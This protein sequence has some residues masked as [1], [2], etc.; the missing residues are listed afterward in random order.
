[1][2]K[3]QSCLKSLPSDAKYCPFCEVLLTKAKPH[4][5]H[6][7]L[8]AISVVYGPMYS[9]IFYCDEC[10]KEFKERGLGSPSAK[11]CP[12]CGHPYD[13]DN[14]IDETAQKMRNLPKPEIK[15]KK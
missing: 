14:C 7:N 3:C 6:S 15:K 5:F 13:K 1:M 8:D 12:F 10:G 4:R 2:K 9:V 11:I